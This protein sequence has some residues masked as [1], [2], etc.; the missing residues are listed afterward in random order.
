MLNRSETGAFLRLT[1]KR[2][3]RFTIESERIYKVL[4]GQLAVAPWVA[5]DD[6]SIADMA[7]YPWIEYHEWQG[8]DLARYPAI[9]AWFERMGKRP[10]VQAG[11]RIPWP[12]GEY[13]PSERGAKVR[14][15]VE[16]NLNDP[17]F[18]LHATEEDAVGPA[19]AASR[20]A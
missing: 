7:W 20:R 5:G 10:A 2:H 14:R 13:G 19:M 18:Q 8:Q 1:A 6:Y 12:I 17:R 9:S 4:E 3:K 16:Q 11:V 15:V